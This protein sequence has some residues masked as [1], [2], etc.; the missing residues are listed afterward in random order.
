MVH[1]V[2]TLQ[3]PAFLLSGVRRFSDWCNSCLRL[4]HL[5]RNTRKFTPAA[6]YSVRRRFALAR[7]VEDLTLS[8]WSFV[9]PSAPGV[10]VRERATI[11]NEFLTIHN[12]KT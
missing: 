10:V 9:T 2:M 5:Q 6:G 3:E 7:L 4:Q 11:D 1:T 12:V 8:W